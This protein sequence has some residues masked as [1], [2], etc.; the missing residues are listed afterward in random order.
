MGENHEGVE[1]CIRVLETSDTY[2]KRQMIRNLKDILEQ[3][4]N[5]DVNQLAIIGGRP[6]GWIFSRVAYDDHTALLGILHIAQMHVM[7][8]LDIIRTDIGED[9]DEAD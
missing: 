5:G 9:G 3:V 1:P 4:E 2:A 7:N 8:G 6:G